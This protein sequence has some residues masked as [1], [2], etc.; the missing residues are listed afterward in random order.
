MICLV[1]PL[2]MSAPA[3]PLG[4]TVHEGGGWQGYGAQPRSTF[5]GEVF[6]M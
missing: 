6:R 2:R 4:A 1:T 5:E 3:W